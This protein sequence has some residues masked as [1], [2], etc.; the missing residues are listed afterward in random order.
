[1]SELLS[2]VLEYQGKLLKKKGT[3]KDK[4][5]NEVQWELWHIMFNTG[6]QY[7]WKCAVF[8]GVKGVAPK[9]M[10]E[11]E[12]YKVVYKTEDYQHPEYG[13]QKSKTAVLVE[14]SSKDKQTTG[15]KEAS[16]PSPVLFNE[17]A[18][19]TFVTSYNEAT[20][21]SNDANSMHMLGA[22]IANQHKD[23]FT[24]VIEKCVANFKG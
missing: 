7:P 15:R 21:G 11:G 18:W 16:A 22:Y 6:G 14:Q 8:N 17:T 5:G 23:M 4:E 13:A 19:T 20:K 12:F 3:R 2:E 10:V 1:M 24:E 9:D